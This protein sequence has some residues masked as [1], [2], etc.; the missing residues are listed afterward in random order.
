MTST[1][2][3]NTAIRQVS[4]LALGAAAAACL[5][6][7]CGNR[8]KQAPGEKRAT[9]QV[10]GSDTMVNVAQAWAEEYKKVDPGVEVEVSGDGSGVGIAALQRGTIDIATASRTIK[11][12]D[13]RIYRRP[14]RLI[15]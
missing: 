3:I 13:R 15:G 8:R 5:V 14:V 4:R 7:A 10:K 9:I 11:P 6:C 1:R 2:F 12:E